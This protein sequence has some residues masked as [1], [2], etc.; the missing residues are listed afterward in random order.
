M[1]Q[2]YVLTLLIGVLWLS[3]DAWTRDASCAP[4]VMLDQGFAPLPSERMNS[5]LE[6]VRAQREFLNIK[7]RVA[8]ESTNARLRVMDPWV[9]DRVEESQRR[10]DISRAWSEQRRKSAEEEHQERINAFEQIFQIDGTP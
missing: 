5:W 6:E 4:P 3:S 8:K 10:R 7:H 1:P 9:A 2:S